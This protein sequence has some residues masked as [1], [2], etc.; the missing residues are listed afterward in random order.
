VNRTL[1]KTG[2]RYLR[3][4]PWQSLLMVLGISL[5]VA[6][7]IAI[8][9]ANASAS[10]AFDL[11]AESVAGRATHQIVGGPNGLDGAIYTQLRR[12]GEPLKGF[13]YSSS[14]VV[15]GYLTSPQLGERPL[16][17]L[18][19]DP[20][21]EA[22]FRSYLGHG[23]GGDAAKSGFS[24]AQGPSAGDLTVF[25][26]Q[27]G[28][29]LL[30]QQ[31]AARY[32]L[33]P[34][35]TLKADLDSSEPGCRILLESG[36]RQSLAFLAGVI[37][38]GGDDASQRLLQRTLDGLI[39]VDISSAQEIL[40]RV[41]TLDH[42]DLLLPEDETRLQAALADLKA[43]LP[44]GV[45]VQ[46]VSARQGTIQ[47]M[48]AAFRVNLTALS[49]LALVVGMF[50]IYNTMTFAV[51][52]RRGMYGTLR[53]LGVTQAEIF[54]LVLGE[55]LLAGMIGSALGTLLGVLLGQGAVQ[56]VTQTINDLFFVVSVRG[57]QVP[58]GSLVKGIGLGLGATLLSA[59]LP[60]WEAASV[61]PRQALSRSGLES[62]AGRLIRRAAWAGLA[63]IGLGGLLLL[64][65][66]R[67]LVISFAAT[68]AIVVGCAL[69]SP[70]ATRAIMRR[71]SVPL[72]RVWGSLGRMAP[73]NVVGSLSRTAIAVMALMVAVSVTIG[74][75]VMIGSFR[76][77]VQAWLSQTLAGDVYISA[78]SLNANQSAVA[79]DPGLIEQLRTW[80]GVERVD[81]LR[82]AR[83]ESAYGLV[84]L[85]ATDNFTVAFERE[86]LFT[87]VSPDQIWEQMLAGGV[88]LSE[89]L[90][91]RLDLPRQGAVIQL[92]SDRG[93]VDFPVLGVYYDYAS[94]TGVLM[95]AQPVYRQYWDDSS[96]TASALRLGEGVDAAETT[97]QIE[98]ALGQFGGQNLVVRP[99]QELRDD[100]LV[101]FDRTFAITSALQLLAT[102]VAFVGVLSA[103]LSLELERQRELGI[104]RAV[105][106]TVRQM[107]GLVFL[108]TGLMG[109]AAGLLSMPTGYLLALILVYI[110]NRRSF[111]WTLQ[112]Q[113]EWQ[114]FAAALLVAL[115][116]A[117]LAGIYPAWR[118][119][120]M[121]AAEALRSE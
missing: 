57:V 96:I 79:I 53:C 37:L 101:V 50:L 35:P 106:L 116:A 47:E 51:V 119:G 98:D 54:R 112:M 36:G 113:V 92:D 45:Q 6:V 88:L 76:R 40:G 121:E 15:S 26:T 49:L 104:L 59:A 19:V 63:L 8:D 81:T 52:Q 25:L 13:P 84:Q 103:L 10:R 3:R 120:R 68:F 56:L 78:P 86:F 71:L 28:A 109:G 82:S 58:L 29:L 61:P 99:N 91:T 55:A 39:L 22:P 4:H 12:E 77:T 46:P 5:G 105:G 20:F 33:Q 16:Q 100:V 102:V 14:P 117:M 107:W 83:L 2:W 18:G 67:S 95:M 17:I 110:I 73:R 75:S 118:L 80:P 11:S 48:T 42:I 74:V 70:L 85:S 44:A 93:P 64:L 87:T 1:F 62:K 23:L 65:P 90:Y 115:G 30:S 43:R 108:E 21:A 94:T 111:G 32:G 72:G 27:P 114:P 97:R 9:L 89:P 66:G 24:Q 31:T 60:A 7:V 34:C 41:G 38:P 69:L